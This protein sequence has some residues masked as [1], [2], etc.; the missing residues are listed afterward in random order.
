[1]APL[2][3]DG[4]NQ[5]DKRDR[6]EQNNKVAL[7][8]ILRLAAI[9]DNFQARKA[10]GHEKN[11]EAINPKPAAFPGSFDFTRE[12]GRVGNEPVRQDQRHD[13]DGNVDK[14]DPTPTPVVCD[15]PSE[16]RA[17]HRGSHDGHAVESE[18]R[19]PFL[20]RERV[21]ENG[22]L[23]RSEATAPDTLQNTKEDEQ[24]QRGSEPT[25]Q[26]AQREEDNAKHVVAFT[27]EDAAQPR[28]K[29]KYDCI[30]Y[31]IACQDPGA[32]VVANGEAAGNMG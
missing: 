9:E 25:Q 14:E 12:L 29:R 15:P 18:S 13:P 6:K 30:R 20:R 5:C 19:G 31:Q 32:L 22:L 26:G 1:M 24:A 7:E 11:P 3:E 17:E 10:E 23:D 16:R 21:H 2:P 27:P 28:G 8:P 4:R